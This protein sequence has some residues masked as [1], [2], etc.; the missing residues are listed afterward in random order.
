MADGGN[1]TLLV[2]RGTHVSRQIRMLNKD[3]D[4]VLYVWTELTTPKFGGSYSLQPLV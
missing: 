2:T 3:D 4:F 1:I